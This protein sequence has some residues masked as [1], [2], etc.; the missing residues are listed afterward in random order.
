MR[1]GGSLL[2]YEKKCGG[3]AAINSAIPISCTET[4]PIYL[5]SS[6][7]YGLKC[8][9]PPMTDAL[10]RCA[11]CEVAYEADAPRDLR[12][13]KFHDM[14][15]CIDALKRQLAAADALIERCRPYVEYPTNIDMPLPLTWEQWQERA[16]AL[17]ADID[18]EGRKG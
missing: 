8:A 4:N 17:L 6:K 11:R 7:Q 15:L 5:N 18:C 13:K 1:C 10:H 12:G 16:N 14:W 3:G 2:H 9:R